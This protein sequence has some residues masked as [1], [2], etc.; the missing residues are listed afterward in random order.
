MTNIRRVD[1]QTRT[2]YAELLEILQMLEASRT[3]ADLKRTFTTKTIRGEV[4]A[5]G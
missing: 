3:I 4:E 2:L 1:L 5:A